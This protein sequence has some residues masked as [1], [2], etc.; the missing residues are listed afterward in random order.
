MIQWLRRFWEERIRIIFVIVHVP[1]PPPATGFILST[2]I[3][4][5]AK[6]KGNI[7]S[8]QFKKAQFVTALLQPIAKDA[9]GNTVN[10]KIKDGSVLSFSVADPT[11]AV[12]VPDPTNVLG[13]K[14]N[15]VADGTTGYTATGVNDNG[16]TISFSDSIVIAD[17]PPPPPVATGFA[18]TYS[19][20][21]AQDQP[22]V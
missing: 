14:I 16:D 12:I 18:V 8:V 17:E 10:S 15:G 1:W 3:I 2:L 22:A 21:Q 4:D 9:Q 11:V 20:P 19:D 13:F 5:G 7:M 6:I